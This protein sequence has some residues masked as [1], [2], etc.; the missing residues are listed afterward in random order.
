MVQCADAFFEYILALISLGHY[1]YHHG[2]SLK[3]RQFDQLLQFCRLDVLRT[4]VCMSCLLAIQE[5]Q[6]SSTVQGNVNHKI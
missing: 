2:D 5:T 1:F 3:H 6:C 4:C